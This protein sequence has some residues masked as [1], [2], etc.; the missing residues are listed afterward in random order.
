M[1][2]GV[3]SAMYGMSSTGTIFD[4]TPLL[5]CRPGHLVA[6]LQAALDRDVH[7]DHL[8]HARRQ[9]VALRQ[10]LLLLLEH[11]VELD[12]RCASE[13]FIASSWRAASSL[14][15]RMSNQSWRLTPSR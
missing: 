7:L 4:T 12:A 1:S 8:L 15:S 6:R 14:A 3:P 11:L 5:P 9:L 10:L 13:S 2:T